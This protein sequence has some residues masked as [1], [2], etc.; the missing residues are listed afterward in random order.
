MPEVR[1]A[2]DGVD[3]GEDNQNDCDHCKGGESFA[4]R[5]VALGPGGVLI[6][7]NKLEEEVGQ[8]SKVK[9]LSRAPSANAAFDLGGLECLQWWQSCPKSSLFE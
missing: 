7:S 2:H 5:C 3:D 9:N 6:H 8:S 1:G 4:S